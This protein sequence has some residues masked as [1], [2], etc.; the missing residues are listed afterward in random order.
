M[1]NGSKY[2]LYEF[3]EST[4]KYSLFGNFRNSLIKLFTIQNIHYTGT[5]C[6]SLI[7]HI[8]VKTPKKLLQNRCSSGNLVLDISDH[9]P[10]FSFIDIKAQ[11]IKDR[12]S[13]IS[14][15]LL[16]KELNYLKKDYPMKM[17][18]LKIMI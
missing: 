15:Y 3:F 8:F 13:I 18:L 14:D 11:I 1:R 12:P 9:L 5:K 17:H 10:N 7:D 2:S 6:I 4:Q 16:K